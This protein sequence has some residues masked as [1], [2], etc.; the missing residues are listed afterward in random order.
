MAQVLAFLCREEGKTY[1]FQPA[2]IKSEDGIVYND[3]VYLIPDGRK[4]YYRKSQFKE[5]YPE[6]V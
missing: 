2:Q 6:L 3:E 1:S 4:K 5:L